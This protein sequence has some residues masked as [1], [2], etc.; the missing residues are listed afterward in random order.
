MEPRR[1]FRRDLRVTPP[2]KPVKRERSESQVIVYDHTDVPVPEPELFREGTG[3]PVP[4]CVG[5][6]PSAVPPSVV[7]E[8]SPEWHCG[9]KAP[10]RVYHVRYGDTTYRLLDDN[11]SPILRSWTVGSSP[12][13]VGPSVVTASMARSPS[14][15]HVAPMDHGQCVDVPGPTPRHL[16]PGFI[17]VAAWK[18]I[19][20]KSGR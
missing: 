1:L 20:A 18:A 10:S 8:Q 5:A 15:S 13:A 11:G 7:T 16:P 9:Q 6:S 2:S 17:T 19:L 3:T 12:L 4:S 14:P